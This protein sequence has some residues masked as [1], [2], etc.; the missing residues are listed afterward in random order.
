[1]FGYHD[2][3]ESAL[4]MLISSDLPQIFVNCGPLCAA[5]LIKA[6]L[7]CTS[8]LSPTTI[9]FVSSHLTRKFSMATHSAFKDSTTGAEVVAA[10]P[11]NVKDR[12]CASCCAGPV[13]YNRLTWHS[14]AVVV[15]GPTAG[16]IG[17]AVLLALAK[18]QPASLVI[19]GRTPS[20]FQTVVDEI[21][22]DYPTVKVVT[23]VLDLSSQESVRTAAR[24]IL[25]NDE[26]PR[27][28]VLINNAGTPDSV[29]R[30]S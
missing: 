15:T 16:S 24:Q 10:F 20:K 17:S 1:M 5:L 14:V 29:A 18:G 7:S 30:E 4:V 22:R 23:V 12:I 11:Q 26:I 2:E 3:R 27:V 8:R 25:E 6:D 19:A 9:T 21:T 28:D 13:L